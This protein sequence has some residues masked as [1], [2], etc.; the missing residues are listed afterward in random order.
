MDVDQ[1][2]HEMITARN[3]NKIAEKIIAKN[4]RKPLPRMCGNNLQS[5]FLDTECCDKSDYCADKR[6]T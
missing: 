3:S 2:L 1:E 4:H 5:V 6:N